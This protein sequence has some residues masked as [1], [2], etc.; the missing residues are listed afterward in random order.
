MVVGN[1]MIA[2]AFSDFKSDKSIT[3]FA[4]GVSNSKELNKKSF[5]REISL[6]S[7]FIN[8]K[9]PFVYFS[10][11]SIHDLSLRHSL[12]VNH[13]KNAEQFVSQSFE[14]YWIFRLPNVIGR[15]SNPHTMTNF[16][17]NSI[18]NHQELKIQSMAHRYFIDVDDVYKTLKKVICNN[19][20]D[21]GVYDL[22]YP[23]AFSVLELV[24]LMEVIVNRKAVYS[25]VDSNANLYNINVS[26]QLKPYLSFDE[27]LGVEYLRNVLEKH[28]KTISI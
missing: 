21:S 28:Y 3:I 10:T 17:F 19:E 15:T 22:F 4:S 27:S 2:N 9:V 23:R 16:F 24:H 13:K 11:S 18:T 7:E 1:G 25:V 14:K 12:Y 6:I 20:L 26:S 8:L 5:Q